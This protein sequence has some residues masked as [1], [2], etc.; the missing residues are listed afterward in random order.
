M[1]CT[2]KKKDS[3]W[4]LIVCGMTRHA[5]SPFFFVHDMKKKTKGHM[6][7]WRDSLCPAPKKK[8]DMGSLSHMW[9]AY[10]MHMEY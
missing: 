1:S 8:G 2:H 4:R 9:I 5:I 10:V 3:Q 7:F 6:F